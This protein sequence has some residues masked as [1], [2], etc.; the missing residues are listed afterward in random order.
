MPEPRKTPGRTALAAAALLATAAPVSA[1]DAATMNVLGFSADGK[2]FAFEEYGIQDGSGFPYAS[3]FYI[4]TATDRFLPSTPVRVTLEDEAATVA[5]ARLRARQQSQMIYPDETFAGTPGHAAGRN[6]ITELTADPF[7]M[8]VNPRPVFPPID[9]P[10]GFAL[11]EVSVAQPERCRDLG[12]IKGFR[13]VR[14]AA[15]PGQVAKTVH[16]DSGIPASR[17]CPLGYAIGGVQTF[18]PQGGNPVFAVLVAVRQ[19][20]FEGPNHRWIAVTGPIPD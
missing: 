8:T 12:V 11:E 9:E 16:R 13:L 3:R 6:A 7:R 10:L 14:T 17:G 19:V 20:G 18:H 5:Q 2:V 1:G 15:A 4:D